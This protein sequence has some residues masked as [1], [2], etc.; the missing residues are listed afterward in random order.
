[1]PP[2]LQRG[3]SAAVRLATRDDDDGTET[4]QEPAAAA[5]GTVDTAPAH[6]LLTQSEA[7]VETGATVGIA[8]RGPLSFARRVLPNWTC[9]V[10]GCC[11]RSTAARCGECGSLRCAAWTSLANGTALRPGA[12]LAPF[13][14]PPVGADGGAR[15]RVGASIVADVV[16]VPPGVV[17]YALP[18]G[19][20]GTA[21]PCKFEL[22]RAEAEAGALKRLGPGDL[23]AVELTQWGLCGECDAVYRIR[24]GIYR[25]AADDDRRAMVE[26]DVDTVS[27]ALDAAVAKKAELKALPATPY[28]AILATTAAI[29]DLSARLAK[30]RAM[31]QTPQTQ[32]PCCGWL[33]LW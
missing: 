13:V 22:T 29:K 15:P 6:D 20:D 33:S 16:R 4:A 28:D 18:V 27:A 23:R 30:A 10:C 5:D 32:C 12:L 14:P 9:G 26:R 7:A 11:G 8:L 17:L 1:M 19:S 3:A 25:A 24:A 2:A 31:T 21:A